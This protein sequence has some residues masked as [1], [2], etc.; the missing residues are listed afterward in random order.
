MSGERTMRNFA[1]LLIFALLLSTLNCGTGGLI[2]PLAPLP[3][4][5]STPVSATPSLTGNWDIKA[6]SAVT[7]RTMESGGLLENNGSQVTGVLHVISASCYQLLDIV[8]LT[9]KISTDSDSIS[10][11]TG[12]VGG[13]VL[14]LTGLMSADRKTLLGGTYS[15]A[16]GCSDGDHGTV[17]GFLVPP[18]TNVYTGTFTSLRNADIVNVTLSLTQ[19]PTLDLAGF[20][21]LTGIATSVNSPCFSGGMLSGLVIGSDIDLLLDTNDHAQ[22]SLPGTLIDSSGKAISGRYQVLSGTCAGDSGTVMLTHD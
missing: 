1:S 3:A 5:P 19:S 4:P 18:F 8:P 2:T 15:I 11:V 6:Q 16:G 20:F 10:L 17:A 22:L 12:S 7:L 21:R 14:T 9:G 13:Q